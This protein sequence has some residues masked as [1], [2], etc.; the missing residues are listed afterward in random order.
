M[1]FEK[2]NIVTFSGWKQENHWEGNDPVGC[3][4][5]TDI[6]A[7]GPD[8]KC[9]YEVVFVHEN[10]RPYCGKYQEDELDFVLTRR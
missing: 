8:D 2:R 6:V 9:I 3:G 10:D 1:K 5:V 4:L 7:D